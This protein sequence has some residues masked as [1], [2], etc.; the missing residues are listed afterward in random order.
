MQHK[1]LPPLIPNSAFRI[2]HLQK[3]LPTRGSLFVKE[4]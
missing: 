3:R 2:P 4:I 1:V